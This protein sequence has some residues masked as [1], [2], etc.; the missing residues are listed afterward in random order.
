MR[1]Y[2]MF[3]DN[4]KQESILVMAENYEKALEYSIKKGY[5]TGLPVG[6]VR[7]SRTETRE[8]VVK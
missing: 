8:L 2:Q 6:R 3:K 4:T 7:T 5:D 1:I